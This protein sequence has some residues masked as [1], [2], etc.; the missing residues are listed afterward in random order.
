[1]KAFIFDTETTGLIANMLKPL[2]RQ[3][4]VIEFYGALV[5]LKN[6]KK[7]QEFESLVRPSIFPRSEATMRETGSRIS[8]ILLEDAPPFKAIAST[9]RSLIE[10]APVIIAHN[11]SFDREMI[12]IEF[13]RLAITLN[14]PAKV[15]C[16][17][18]Q[19]IFLQG[20]R[21]T[22]S[23]LYEYLFTER[24]PNAHRAKPDVEALI[25]ICCALYR[26]GMIE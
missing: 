7:A 4:E 1:M 22:L 14:W 17:V 24:F 11:A 12:D 15:I 19:T 9:V 16:T 20:R 10:T 2:D 26:K 13:A 6:G 25:K 5:N 23:A 21:L 3:P 8:D 18:E